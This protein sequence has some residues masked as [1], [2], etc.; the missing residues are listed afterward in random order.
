MTPCTLPSLVPL[1]FDIYLLFPPHFSSPISLQCHHR[2]AESIH[3]QRQDHIDKFK[4]LYEDPTFVSGFVD[5]S[6]SLMLDSRRVTS[7]ASSSTACLTPETSS[8]SGRLPPPSLAPLTS[9]N[10]LDDSLHDLE[11]CQIG[12]PAQKVAFRDPWLQRWWEQYQVRRCSCSFPLSLCSTSPM[13]PR[14]D[15][16]PGFPPP[17]WKPDTVVG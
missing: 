15:A 10:R 17:R 11:R 5:V 4:E 3:L 1:C 7:S 6:P 16:G 9:T 12:L 13:L 14:E 2:K 8:P